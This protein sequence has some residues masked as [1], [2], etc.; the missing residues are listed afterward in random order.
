MSIRALLCL[1][2]LCLAALRAAAADGIDE[3]YSA[4]TLSE[5]QFRIGK[6]IPGV[7]HDVIVPALTPDERRRLADLRFDFPKSAPGQEPLAFWRAGDAVHFSAA[8]MKFVADL[9]LAYVWLGRNGFT[10]TSLDKYML[11]LAC[12]QQAAAP[13]EPRVALH[14]PDNARNDPD[15]DL[16]A[17][18]LTRNAFQFILLA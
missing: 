4:D 1:L 2:V 13:P 11:M 6:F 3:I 18:R 12:W 17:T 14:V 5:W 9:S 15:T 8:S 16:Y 7:Y 10:D